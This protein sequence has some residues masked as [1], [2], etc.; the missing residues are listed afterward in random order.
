MA[1]GSSVVSVMRWHQSV[2]WA[3]LRL[4]DLLPRRPLTCLARA[5]TLPQASRS[6]AGAGGGVLRSR[7]LLQIQGLGG[8]GGRRVSPPESH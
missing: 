6:G 3:Y 8:E 2:V 5:L 4:E 7:C 1:D